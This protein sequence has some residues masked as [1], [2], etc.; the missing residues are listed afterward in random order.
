M[1]IY[2]EANG[3]GTVLFSDRAVGAISS[4]PESAAAEQLLALMRLINQAVGDAMSDL[5]MVEAILS[6]EEL[7]IQHVSRPLAC[8]WANSLPARLTLVCISSVERHVH[9]YS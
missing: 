2:F 9:R 1:G 8:G 6:M 7:T 5:L 4:A 3:H